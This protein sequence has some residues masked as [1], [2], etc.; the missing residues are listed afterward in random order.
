MKLRPGSS[1]IRVSDANLGVLSC[2]PQRGDTI[3]YDQLSHAS[4]RD[5]ARLSF[6]RSFSFAHN[7]LEEL[8]QRLRS[9]RG[10]EA[11]GQI[12]NE[13][14]QLFVVTESVF[15]MDGDQ[16]PLP[17]IVALCRR[18][19]AQLIVDEAHATGVVGSKGEG[20]VQVQELCRRTVWPVSIR[21]EKRSVVMAPLYWAVRAS[22]I[23]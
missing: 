4:I 9:G 8:E 20:L 17:E 19:G 7:D 5:G 12:G 11:S 1:S 23:F 10:G 13:S 14:G 6:A 2:I 16:A 21:S 22:G 15:S 18:Y 3:L